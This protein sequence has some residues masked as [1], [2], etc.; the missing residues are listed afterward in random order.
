MKLFTIDKNGKFVK[1]KEQDFKIKNKE[2]DLEV[3]LENNPEYF[4][5][6]SKILII[7][8]QVTTNLS[9]FIDLLGV[10]DQGNTVV[11]ELKREKTPR[12]TIA[13]LLEYASFVDNL[14]YDQLN[15][16]FQGYSNEE[17]NLDDYHK[18]YF[19]KKDSAESISWNKASKLAIVAQDIT[20]EIKQ[21]SMYLRKR[22]LDVYCLEF[23]Y[24]INEE[25]SRMISS[26]F[27]IGEESFI[28][29]KVSSNAPLPK[30]TKEEFLANL[31]KNG[32][33][34]FLRLFEFI[35]KNKLSIRWGSKGFSAN[36]TNKS[37]FI[38]IFFGYP[39]NSPWGQS[40]ATGFGQIEKKLDDNQPII[41]FYKEKI[42]KLK[43]FDESVNFFSSQELRWKIKS[44]NEDQLN[45]LI[46]I[47]KRT[48]ELVASAMN[49]TSRDQ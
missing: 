37:D 41:K 36:V 30:T 40:I 7:G 47:L 29:Q 49:K 3:L 44:F 20:P 4:F 10:D 35:E 8:R 13:Q 39:I 1:Y 43:L 5:E 31:D 45:E 42:E 19:S 6:Q 12:E 16:I 38:G 32:K 18:E 22:G 33:I 11:I 28:K 23:K 15:E 34:V 17:S 21:T 2:V 24:F 46:N 26:D 48:V 27:V 25:N 9:T 14:D